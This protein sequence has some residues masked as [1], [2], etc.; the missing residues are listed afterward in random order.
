[1]T[2]FLA[3]AGP[4][5]PRQTCVPLVAAQVK[6]VPLRG[7]TDLE[8]VPLRGGTDLETVPLVAAQIL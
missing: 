1:V 6:T 3:M 2:F 4:E 8:T 7:G 5:C